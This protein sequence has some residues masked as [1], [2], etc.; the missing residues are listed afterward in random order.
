MSRIGP[1]DAGTVQL[2]PAR[3]I[4]DLLWVANTRH[5]PAGHWFARATVDT[6]D[7]D[8]LATAG[9]AVRYLAD[10]HV[11]IP[12][13]LPEAGDLADLGALR[14]MVRGLIETGAGW[15]D[16]ARALADR[17]TYRVDAAGRLSADGSAWRQVVGELVLPLIELVRQR[18][19]LALCGNPLCR[20]VF[21]DGSRSGTRRWCDD[22]GCGNRDRVRR[23]RSVPAQKT[24][25]ASS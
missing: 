9:A 4:T 20:L 12:S 5:G 19:R 16:A 17:A 14:E 18:D 25:I 21:L 3:S 6:G 1:I 24:S 11:R 10:H 2:A 8:H 23:H 7:H 22:R 15:T 13:T